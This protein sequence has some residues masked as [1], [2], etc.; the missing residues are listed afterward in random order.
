MEAKAKK[1]LTWVHFVVILLL[2]FGVNT[3]RQLNRLLPT[4]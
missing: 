2:M 4:G 1:D 3:F